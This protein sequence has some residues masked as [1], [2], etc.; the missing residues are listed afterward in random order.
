MTY[1]GPART[2]TRRIPGI[3][4]A[5][6]LVVIAA[7]AAANGYLLLASSSST[8]ASPIDVLR[9]EHRAA[10]GEADGAVPDG[11]TVFDDEIP[12]VANL[13]P[14]LLGALRQAATTAADE[15]VGFFV[16]SGW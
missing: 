15:G 14:A 6:L 10:P 3:P 12:G 5:G 1:S 13:N 2:T 11:T 8:A 16:D 9:S 7:I 4:V